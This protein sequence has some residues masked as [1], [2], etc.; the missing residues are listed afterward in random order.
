LVTLLSFLGDE[1]VVQS[2]GLF[3][4]GFRLAEHCADELGVV[5]VV[6]SAVPPQIDVVIVGAGTAGLPCAIAAI[7]AGARVLVIDKADRVGGTLHLSGG[8]F[9]AAGTRRQRAHG[10]D[11]DTADRHYDDVQRISDHTARKDIA[12]RAVDLAPAM[13][14][15]LDDCGFE[16]DP[17][18]PRIVYGHEPYDTARTYYGVREGRSL[19]ELFTPMIESRVGGGRLTLLLRT[20][21]VD[22]VIEEGRCV[23]VVVTMADGSE[24][25]IRARNVVLATGGY[26]AAPALF[27]EFDGAPLVS[28]AATTSTGDGLTIA[29]RHGA[30]IAGI[31]TYL[32]TFG[33][34]PSPDD[35]ERVQWVDRPLLVATERVPWEIYVGPDGQ[36][37]VAEDEPSVDLK[38]RA[39]TNVPTM[40][41]HTIFDD[42][43]VDESPNIVVGWSAEEMRARAG[44]RPGVFVANSIA[45]LAIAA[46][47]PADELLA[48]VDEY[49]AAVDLGVD[50][51][52]GRTTFPA[53]IEQA[54]FY[55]MRNHGITLITF[56]G[57]DV[58]ADLRIRRA[59]ETVIDGLYG[60]GELLGSAAYMGNS[61]C[62]GMLVGPCI[63][64]GRELGERLAAESA[65]T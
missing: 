37:F 32:P 35:P 54:P 30:H 57:V 1:L 28:A 44:I 56:A 18:T 60:L 19:L 46:G 65:R 41:F 62:S 45:E 29:R 51:A 53:R 47:L 55:A 23:G 36:R 14:D 6:S 2:E 13:V 31:G 48:T 5:A 8:H 61:F 12:R 63:S 4:T 25:V 52:F 49:N 40:T 39:L 11:G 33:G 10:V 27:A 7:D 22:L 26:G 17:V 42:R 21:L 34:M 16:F 43:A 24:Q 50:A 20:E 58:D 9:S 3:G 15:W 59:D 64:F 38:E